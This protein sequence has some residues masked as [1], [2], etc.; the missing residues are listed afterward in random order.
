M[1]IGDALGIALGMGVP[2]YFNQR[3][4]RQAREEREA[5]RVRRMELQAYNERMSL[6]ELGLQDGIVTMPRGRRARSLSS[7]ARLLDTVELPSSGEEFSIYHDPM[8][9]EGA[10]KKRA[11]QAD[12]RSAYAEIVR[13]FPDV[14][15]ETPYRPDIDYDNEL[16]ERLGEKAR[17]REQSLR[18]QAAEATETAE[19]NAM[20]VA[21]DIIYQGVK[22]GSHID[23]IYQRIQEDGIAQKAG[24]S[25]SK[26]MQKAKEVVTT[27]ESLQGGDQ[28]STRRKEVRDSLDKIYG[29]ARGN[30]EPIVRDA[31][32][33]IS[34]DGTFIAAKTEDEI[35]RE[36]ERS[37]PVEQR[38]AKV[39]AA[40]RYFSRKKGGG[41]DYS[42][43]GLDEETAK[44]L[45]AAGVD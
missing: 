8:Q 24:Y 43:L 17:T 33:G 14:Y 23:S 5:E 11:E 38:A 2:S 7:E 1:G 12:N 42:A 21:D 29:E 34:R 26:V 45:K 18:R 32:A 39:A 31:L 28:G 20:R 30:F 22:G 35:I 4:I 10:M 9:T 3:S 40:R 6:L 44:L 27:A 41:V 36:L 13:Q 19:R 25:R 37:F 16:Q 15:K